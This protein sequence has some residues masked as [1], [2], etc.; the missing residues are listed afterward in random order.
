MPCGSPMPGP[1]QG[2]EWQCGRMDAVELRAARPADAGPIEDYHH[3]CFLS[4]YA[5]QVAA[6]SFG[7]PDRAGTRRQLRDWFSPGSDCATVVAVDG[8]TPVGHVT[9]SGHRLVHLFVEPGH[10]GRGLGR[11]LLARGE[12]MLRAGGH[13]DVELHARVENVA[14]IAFYVGQGWTVTDRLTRTVEH[15]ISYD[16]RV[17]VTHVS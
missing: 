4:T 12:A 8:G 15:G 6:G 5:V 14:A 7:P 2:S 16:E 1:R 13:A 10:Q 11:L 17:L 3:R 9:V